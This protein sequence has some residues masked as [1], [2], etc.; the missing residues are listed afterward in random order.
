MADHHLTKESEKMIKEPT[1]IDEA[2]ARALALAI[3]A[4]TEAKSKAAIELAD[5]FAAHMTH[6]RVEAAR[7]ESLRLVSSI[8]ENAN[9]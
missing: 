9:G 6:E 8:L 3:A 2:L 5:T 7:V 1:S 4:P